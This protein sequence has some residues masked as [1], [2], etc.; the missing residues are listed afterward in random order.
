MHGIQNYTPHKITGALTLLFII[1]YFLELKAGFVY[2]ILAILIVALSVFYI[3][4]NQKLY[5]SEEGISIR[6]LFKNKEIQWSRINKIELVTLGMDNGFDELKLSLKDQNKR[7]RLE[8]P[9]KNSS[10]LIQAILWCTRESKN[11]KNINLSQ[12]SPYN[13]DISETNNELY[14]EILISPFSK[15]WKVF[16]IS[17]SITAFLYIVNVQFNY[18]N[19]QTSDIIIVISLIIT[20]ISAI[21]LFLSYF[22]INKIGVSDKYIMIRKRPYSRKRLYIKR[23]D[24]LDFSIYRNIKTG[25]LIYILNKDYSHMVFYIISLSNK[26]EEE[27]NMYLS[28]PVKKTFDRKGLILFEQ[29]Q[30]SRE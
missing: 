28:V 26:S 7:I 16:L 14:R 25:Y 15:I 21:L 24:I 4:N 29:S 5:L 2:I 13:I 27:F 8:L 6:S 19:I 3:I 1:L 18:D 23:S 20:F 12:F 22:Q 11:N 9:Y 30:I 10:I 17:F